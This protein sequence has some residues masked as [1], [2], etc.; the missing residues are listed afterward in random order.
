MGVSWATW[1][2][3]TPADYAGVVRFGESPS[4]LTSTTRVADMR[5][6]E[7]CGMPSPSLHFTTMTGLIAGRTYYYSISEPRCG[8]T[9]P[10][11]FT[12]PRIVGDAS[13]A[14][15]MRIFAYGDMGISNSEPTAHFITDRVAAGVSSAPDLVLH[16][17]DISYADNRGAWGVFA[18]DCPLVPPHPL[19]QPSSSNRR[20]PDVR[21]CTGHLLQ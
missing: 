17:G 21:P 13:T 8:A 11:S 3:A 1:A 10:V 18:L 16:A 12:A 6:Y 5:T 2:N 7:L 9:A 19:T 14:Y 4:S 15:P 20:M